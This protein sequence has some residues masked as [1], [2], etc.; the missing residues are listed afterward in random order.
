MKRASQAANPTPLKTY[1]THLDTHVQTPETSATAPTTEKPV[2]APESITRT[3]SSKKLEDAWPEAGAAVKDVAAIRRHRADN[4]PKFQG[5]VKPKYVGKVTA[6]SRRNL[7]AL[8]E[9]SAQLETDYLNRYPDAAKAYMQVHSYQSHTRFLDEP[10]NDIPSTTSLNAIGWRKGMLIYV[11]VS[12]K[13]SKVCFVI[14]AAPQGGGGSLKTEEADEHGEL[15]PCESPC[16]GQEE[17]AVLQ[18]P[19]LFMA[20]HGGFSTRENVIEMSNHMEI[21]PV[22]VQKVVPLAKLGRGAVRTKP[23]EQPKGRKYND[24]DFATNVFH[25]KE[26]QF[27]PDK[28]LVAASGGKEVNTLFFSFADMRERLKLGMKDPEQL[29]Y[30]VEDLRDMATSA[31]TAIRLWAH[32][33]DP[34]EVLHFVGV[35]TGIFQHSVCVSVAV[36]LF[37]LALHNRQGVY[38]GSEGAFNAAKKM[39]AKVCQALRD[40]GQVQLTVDAF[41]HKLRELIETHKRELPE[42]RK[43]EGQ[44][45]CIG[46]LRKERPDV[47]FP[48]PPT[49]HPHSRRIPPIPPVKEFV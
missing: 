7:A 9:L 33:S 21:H 19:G 20:I 32:N 31:G 42:D 24:G 27:R 34:D 41:V 15:K 23:P 40:E 39:G 37:M 25:A 12:M 26:H 1:T 47:A 2:A 29:V 22:M 3:L 13:E 14:A 45:W 36:T 16:W 48:F 28:A 35:G 17:Q 49:E 43:A 18:M 5:A 30:T 44:H 46:G 10:I 6:E 8:M 38:Y 4:W 11:D